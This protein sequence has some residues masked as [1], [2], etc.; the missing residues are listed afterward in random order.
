MAPPPIRC[1]SNSE[2]NNNPNEWHLCPLESHKC[3]LSLLTLEVAMRKSRS[4]LLS[5]SICDS[6]LQRTEATGNIIILGGSVTA[7]HHSV[8]CVCDS[9]EHP[10]CQ[11]DP[12]PS[13]LPL[14][15]WSRYLELWITSFVKSS[16]VR[17]INLSQSGLSSGVM[18]QWISLRLQEANITLTKN[19]IFI[20]D[21]STNDALSSGHG[22]IE[23]LRSGLENLVNNIYQLATR[24]SVEKS[25]PTIILLELEPLRNYRREIPQDWEGINQDGFDYSEVYVDIASRYH[26]HLWSLRD[27]IWSPDVD[28]TASYLKYLRG[29]CG[30]HPAWH[31]HLFYADFIS[32]LIELNLKN[33]QSDDSAS[34]YLPPSHHISEYNKYHIAHNSLLCDSRS[35]SAISLSPTHSAP[36]LNTTLKNFFFLEERKGTFGWVSRFPLHA[37]SSIDRSHS[38][39]YIQLVVPRSSFHARRFLLQVQYLMTYSNAGIFKISLCGYQLALIDTL[40]NDFKTSRISVPQTYQFVYD[41]DFHFFCSRAP[42]RDVTVKIEHLFDDSSEKQ[43]ERTSHQKIRIDTILL[44]PLPTRGGH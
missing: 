18:A 6:L 42:G 13:S 26:L 35:Q 21:H 19:D 22:I 25:P 43:N 40:W 30:T 24:G 8:G 36:S 38:P 16:R 9:H 29:F 12:P 4:W 44:C 11:E 28:D 14:C 15:S 32:S 23:I 1:F 10:Q 37:L 34:F 27:Y 20:L 7:G 2:K 31:V 17:T 41:A 5:P 3:P 33:C 39:H